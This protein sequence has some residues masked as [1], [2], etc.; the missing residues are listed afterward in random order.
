MKHNLLLAERVGLN[1]AM[2]VEVALHKE[3]GITDDHREVVAAFV[4]K[5]EPRF[6]GAPT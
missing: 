1:E 5:R 4:E 3:C 6:G 2:D